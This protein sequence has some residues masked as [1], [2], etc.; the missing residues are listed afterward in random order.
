M[1]NTNKMANGALDY[2][3]EANGGLRGSVLLKLSALAY[4]LA[5]LLHFAVRLMFPEAMGPDNTAFL[6][7]LLVWNVALFL[8]SFAFTWT[9]I[10]PIFSRM[11]LAV[12]LL[13][14][15]QAVLLLLDLTRTTML[16]VPP[17]L[18]TLGRALLLACFALVER[19]NL[20]KWTAL[21]L[22][23][24]SGFH[25]VR[26]L[27][28]GLQ[29]WPALPVPWENTMST[30]IMVITSGLLFAV[31]RSLRYHEDQWARDNQPRRHAEFEDFNNP[32]NRD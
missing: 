3:A 31:G 2:W 13:S 10:N 27:L 14:G 12:G 7:A 15:L 21:L 19:N 28:R 16:P 20:G 5:A 11:G 9:G 25:F 6:A 17:S 32:R 4:L 18:L 22:A 24:V 30:A 29:I 1:K 26:V 8:F 23:G